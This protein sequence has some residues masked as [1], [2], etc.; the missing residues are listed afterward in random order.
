MIL[1]EYADEYPAQRRAC[2]VERWREGVESTT[3]PRRILQWRR[4]GA[5]DGYDFELD[6]L[7]HK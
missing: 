5:L 1:L 7:K 6:S 3:I 2:Q 4:R